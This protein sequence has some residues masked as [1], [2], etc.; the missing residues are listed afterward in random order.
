MLHCGVDRSLKKNFEILTIPPGFSIFVMKNLLQ[1]YK[2]GLVVLS[3]IIFN[4]ESI[5]VNL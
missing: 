3:T 4:L 2:Y 5:M 1:V